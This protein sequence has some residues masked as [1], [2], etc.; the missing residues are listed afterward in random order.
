MA[1]SKSTQPNPSQ[2]AVAAHQILRNE[3]PWDRDVCRSLK[4]QLWLLRGA[5]LQSEKQH[6]EVISSVSPANRDSARNLVHYLA[7]RSGDLRAL[8]DKL[9]WLG[10]S[11][12]GRAEAHVL[13][14]VDKVLGILHRLLEEPW[15]DH[16]HEEP[17][18]SVSSR[19]LLTLHSKQLLGKATSVRPVRI[20]VTLGTEAGSD[21]GLVRSLVDSGMDIARINCAHDDA[22]VWRAMARHV[23]K[24]AKAARREVKVLMDL[25]GPK[26]RTGEIAR[27]PP[28]LKLKPKR[29]VMGFV[30]EPA[31][32]RLCATPPS[33]GADLVSVLQVDGTW[34]AKL[35]LGA[36][37]ELTDAR[38]AKRSL[39]VIQRE[40]EGVLLA[41]HKTTY[42][43]PDTFFSAKSAGGKKVLSVYPEAMVGAPGVIHLA[44]GDTLHILREGAG[45]PAESAGA[46]NATQVAPAAISC[47]LP[48]V[49]DQVEKGERIFLDDGR[50]GGVIRSVHSNFLAVEIT[51][52]RPTGE[53]LESDK[54]INFPDSQ[55]NL[56]AL[57]EKD[58]ADLPTVAELADMV[59][60][61]FVQ[62]SEDIQLLL[63]AL[64]QHQRADMGVIL[65]IETARSFENLPALMLTAMAAPASG[66]MIAR[67]DLAVECGFERL[68]EVQEE[69]LWCAQAA[70]MPVIW[71]TQVLE[72]MAKTGMPSRAEISD[73]GLGVRAECVMLNKG[74]F[75]TEA[76]TT[77]DDILRRMAGHQDKKRPLLR[78]LQAWG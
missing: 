40:E 20:M 37:I 67:G 21:Y 75:I 42:I 32:L 13:A 23:R 78:A 6:A 17:A 25:G 56:P 71:A 46:E 12:L 39:L 72:G 29:D 7:F 63:S 1:R 45:T 43:T 62:R 14:S 36:R 76:I 16:S 49:L 3:S 30:V 70:H 15:Q 66:V 52:C 41:A 10:L 35:R 69:I 18:G 47:T 74:P 26:I 64:A 50:I 53:K 11:S 27:Q 54:G 44:M 34:L 9:A 4:E 60:L 5:M 65:K 22:E 61:S 59:G 48:Q 58:L 19:E 77:L 24:A 57:T 31:L 28:V 55:L 2:S 8:Q 33:S 68:A 38:A 51:Q 73:A